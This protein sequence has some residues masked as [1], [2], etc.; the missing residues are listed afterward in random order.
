MQANWRIRSGES[1]QTFAGRNALAIGQ[2]TVGGSPAVTNV[3]GTEF[4]RAAT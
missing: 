4:A 2:L 3:Q 1:T